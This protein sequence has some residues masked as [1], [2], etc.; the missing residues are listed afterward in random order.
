MGQDIASREFTAADFAAFDERLARE[1][2]ILEQWLAEERFAEA[3]PVGGA[4]LEAWLTDRDF[5]P[6]PLN[7]VLLARL[8]DPL[9]T[10]ELA[11]FNVEL[12]TAPARLTGPALARMQAD[13]DATWQRCRNGMA[14]LGGR[15]VTI[16]ILPTI[17]Q[18]DLTRAAMTPIARFAALNDQV[19]AHRGGRALDIDIVGH[20]HLRTSHPDVMLE[21]ATTSFQ[22]HMQ[23]PASRAADYFNASLV[24]SAP[25]VAAGA[26]SPYL[27]GRDL[28]A[29]TRIP[30]FEQAVATGGFRGA[31][32]GPPRRVGFGTGYLRHSV[33]E[34]FRE[35]RE[36]FPVLLPTGFDA[37]DEPRLP[38]LQLQ[39]GTIWRWNRPLIG[40]DAAGTPHIRIEH[41]TLPSGP[42]GAD[43]IANAAFYYGLVEHY[44]AEPGRPERI[45]PFATARDNFYACARHGLGARVLRSD[46]QH[47]RVDRLIGE[48]LLDKAR[49]GLAGLGLDGANIDHYLGLIEDRVRSGR[50]G[51]A[52]QRAWVAR[53]GRDMAALTAAYAERQ[54]TGDPVHAWTL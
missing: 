11:R 2:A 47:Q 13:L 29:E 4:E 10:T 26:N 9:L 30:L 50:N 53:H 41:R 52:W 5:R 49:A 16:G 42:S 27:F 23:V 22:V 36:H 45:V 40:F 15:L 38:H 18:A 20:E 51:A 43:A 3:Q 25:L 1:T 7:D 54:A 19:L 48:H 28:W 6:A 33:A 35:N 44:A 32:H 8:Q 37:A 34:C 31:A 14:A 24:A 12:N 17:G 21:S 39:N 46:G